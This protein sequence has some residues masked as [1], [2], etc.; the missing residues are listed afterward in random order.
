MYVRRPESTPNIAALAGALADPVRMRVCLQLLDGRAWTLTELSKQL[1]VAKS[2]MSEHVS[3]LVHEGVLAERRQ[4]RHRYV[5]I[6][7]N[8]VADWLEHTGSLAP[9]TLGSAPTMNAKRRDEK[10][11]EARTCY[12]HLAGRLGVQLASA[13]SAHGWVDGSSFVTDPG[14]EEILAAWGIEVPDRVAT[15]RH[16]SIW[17]LDWTERRSHMG[18]WLGD[19]M[20]AV[21]LTRGWIERQPSSRAIAVTSTGRSALDWV[22]DVQEQQL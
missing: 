14:R 19:E 5:Q 15:G 8:E 16:V 4:G 9:K 21:F 3:L 11:A 10:L 6:A 1:E 13:L 7:S 20:C 18:G 17:C 2:S 22:L 12:K